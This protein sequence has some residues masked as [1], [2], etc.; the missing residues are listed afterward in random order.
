MQK[1]LVYGTGWLAVLFL[2]VV[3][4]SIRVHAE[5]SISAQSSP[6][7]AKQ[8]E[9]VSVT[10]NLQGN[11][12]VSSVFLSLDYDNSSLKYSGITWGAVSASDAASANDLGT[13]VQINLA[14]P[15]G[16]YG[17]GA[18]CT[19]S[20]QAL[21]DVSNPAF[22]LQVGNLVGAT[23]DSTAAADVPGDSEGTMS[24]ET[25]E[26]DNAAGWEE[27]TEDAGWE[28]DEEESGWEEDSDETA[29]AD[30]ESVDK[31][32]TGG[33][34]DDEAWNSQDKNKSNKKSASTDVDLQEESQS[35]TEDSTWD[36]MDS[37]NSDW[38][39]SSTETATVQ[40]SNN[41]TVSA[42]SRSS[43]G[44]TVDR[45]YK[46]GVGFGNDIFILLF[47]VTAVSAL[48]VLARR[49]KTK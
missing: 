1:K 37:W 23:A 6:S 24:M 2:C 14:S 19:V 39:T 13:S 36:A 22:N 34:I 28:D 48:L 9:T 42:G 4:L 31:S 44:S 17:N 5:P 10:V 38:S 46:T 12:G 20:F 21:K 26:E 43:S 25:D 33:W 3:C 41:T 30:T 7:S 45:T 16:Y 32:S 40:P 49:N 15:A 47:A 8:G 18:L 27:D 11:D 35:E 29:E